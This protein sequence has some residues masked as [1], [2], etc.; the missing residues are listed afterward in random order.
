MKGSHAHAITGH[1]V[2]KQELLLGRQLL[3]REGAKPFLCLK[4][5]ADNRTASAGGSLLRVFRNTK[6]ATRAA[7]AFECQVLKVEVSGDE[8]SALARPSL[9]AFG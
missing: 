1:R 3:T 5:L 6:P 7:L 4:L 2:W 8:S 9:I